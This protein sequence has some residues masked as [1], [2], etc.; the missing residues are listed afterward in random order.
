[1]SKLSETR[2]EELL[3]EVDNYA[4]ILYSRIDIE[5]S[6]IVTNLVKE[7]GCS[8]EQVLVLLRD[9]LIQLI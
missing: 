4:D 1:M 8:R 5:M 9:S 7:Y 6:K 3:N 2:T